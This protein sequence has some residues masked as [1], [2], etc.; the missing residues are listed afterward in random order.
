MSIARGVERRGVLAGCRSVGRI[1]LA[2]VPGLGDYCNS[3]EPMFILYVRTWLF[4]EAN[5]KI[6]QNAAFPEKPAKTEGIARIG[7]NFGTLANLQTV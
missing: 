1:A 3:A 5:R 6:M 2:I 7:G 4:V